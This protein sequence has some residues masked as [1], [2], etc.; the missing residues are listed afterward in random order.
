ML[1]AR[2]VMET[3]SGPQEVL[4][5]YL[6]SAFSDSGGFGCTTCSNV[7]FSVDPHPPLWFYLSVVIV[8]CDIWRDS[9][10]F[11]DISWNKPNV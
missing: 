1:G 11:E 5:K 6:R 2:F 4:V 7:V 8:Y 3:T 9:A 10:L